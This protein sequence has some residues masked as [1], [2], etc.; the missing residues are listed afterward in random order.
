MY[1]IR[2]VV[3]ATGRPLQ[4]LG[5]GLIFPRVTRGR[6]S[7]PGGGTI[8]N[9]CFWGEQLMLDTARP[10]RF[11]EGTVEYALEAWR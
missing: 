7:C 2:D 4:W 10:S 11:G 5:T 1:G 3:M 8:V 6:I 9:G